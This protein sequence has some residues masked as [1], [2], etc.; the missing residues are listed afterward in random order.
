M[1]ANVRTA[2][3]KSDPLGYQQITNFPVAPTQNAPA[4]STTGGALPAATYY[5]K[6][7][8]LTAAG[9]TTASNEQSQVTT[10]TTSSNTVNWGAVANATGYRIYRGTAAGAENTYYQVGAVTSFVD[11]GSAGTAATPPTTSTAALALTVPSGATWALIRAE[12]QN[13]RWR[14]DGTAPTASVGIELIVGEALQYSGDLKAI[15]FIQEA[16]SATLDVAYYA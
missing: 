10:G 14:D 6:V 4:T 12:S 13:V 3:G 15:Q 16:A 9:E 1:S 5:Y 2:P 8:A 7:T 11:T